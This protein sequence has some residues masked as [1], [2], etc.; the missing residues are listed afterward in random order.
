MNLTKLLL[1]VFLCPCYASAQFDTTRTNCQSSYGTT[2][3][4]SRTFRPP[5]L[6][7]NEEF[8]FNPYDAY[9][10]GQQMAQTD[11]LIRIAAASQNA[12]WQA[13][14]TMFTALKEANDSLSKEVE[15]LRQ[16]IKMMKIDEE[17]RR[18][19]EL[20]RRK[21]EA[22]TAPGVPEGNDSVW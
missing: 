7:G 5:Q 13:V 22:V 9:M 20:E 8:T 10:H 4:T 6:E 18:R 17:M 19:G 3:C 1:V 16:E 12:N 2:D 14:A 21:P 11:A 15:L